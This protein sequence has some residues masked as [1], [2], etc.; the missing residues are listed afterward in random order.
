MIRLAPGRTIR[1]GLPAADPWSTA[2]GAPS[3]LGATLYAYRVAGPPLAEP[4]GPHPPPQT[5]PRQ[6]R[7]PMSTTLDATSPGPVSTRRERDVTAFTREFLEYLRFTRGTDLSF[8]TPIDLYTALSLTV[9]DY[10]LE[11]WLDTLHAHAGQSGQPVKFVCYLSAEYLLGRQLG[12][13]LLNA[14]LASWPG[15]RWRELGLD[16]D[17]LAEV[18]VEPGLG[19]GGLG[20]LAACFLDSLATLDVPGV[21]YGIRYEFGIFRQAI[22][23]G[24]QVEQPDEWLR[25]G[26][27]WEFRQLRPAGGGRLRRAHRGG[28]P[29]SGAATGSRWRARAHRPRRPL[30]LPGPGLPQRDGQHPAPVE[31][32]GHRVR[33]TCRSSTPGTTPAPSRTRC[34]RKT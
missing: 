12:N 9:R 32:P 24:W 10:L 5:H 27:P 13:S 33:S 14:D 7:L 16:L 8:A 20:R 1:S 4:R 17:A 31:R 30:Q 11:H 23:D 34:D 26:V 21:G 15:G 6:E 18:E 22:Q 3:P 29:T 28:P 2:G 25:R 19:N